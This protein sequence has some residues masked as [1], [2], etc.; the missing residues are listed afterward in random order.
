M[1][2]I[3]V[4]FATAE[5]IRSPRSFIESTL[6]Y[7]SQRSLLGK[8]LV[9]TASQIRRLKHLLNLLLQR[10]LRRQKPNGD[11]KHDVIEDS[12]N[13]GERFQIRRDK[14]IERLNKIDLLVSQS[15]RTTEIYHTLGVQEKK[16]ITVHSG[17]NH[18]EWIKPKTITS[19]PPTIN[20]ATMNGLAATSKGAYLIL[21]ALYK[22]KE[23]GLT[24]QFRLV[25][26]GYV[27]N[28]IKDEL[29]QFDNVVYKGVY[30]VSNLNSLLEEVHVGIVPSIWEEVYGYVGVEFLA[31]GIPVIGNQLGGIVDYTIDNVTGWLN[32]ASTAEG[33]T[34]IIT[35]IIRNPNQILHLNQSI[36]ANYRQVVKSMDT[37]FE[38]MDEVYRELVQAKQ[39]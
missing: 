36:L 38:K 35:D 18:L 30:D 13:W 31:K 26:M 20:I 29:L 4:K 25:V 12:L 23:A 2:G 33:L 8:S 22:L 11:T 5:K 32:K 16:L 9:T 19:I 15:F 17:L 34:Q 14:N 21:D 7:E 10:S 6:Q 3:R 37:Y 28:D 24:D 39:K 27:L 1:S